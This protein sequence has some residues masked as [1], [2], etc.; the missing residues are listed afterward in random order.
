MFHRSGMNLS[1]KI[2]F[3]IQSRIHIATTDDFCPFELINYYNPFV[4]QK[5]IEKNYDCSDIPDN[6]RQP[7]SVMAKSKTST[8]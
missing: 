2:R 6:K 3:A 1:S 7:V 4:K 8:N 5:L